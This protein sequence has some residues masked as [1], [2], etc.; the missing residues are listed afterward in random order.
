MPRKRIRESEGNV[1]SIRIMIDHELWR[2]F[3]AGCLYMDKDV[4]T[5]L[6]RMIEN[7][8][9]EWHKRISKS[10]ATKNVQSEASEDTGQEGFEAPRPF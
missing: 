8:V 7:W 5:E 9:K 3:R 10:E 4:N 6:N 1:T 2:R